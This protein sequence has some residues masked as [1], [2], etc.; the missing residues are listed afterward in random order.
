MLDNTKCLLTR[1]PPLLGANVVFTRRLSSVSVVVLKSTLVAD[2]FTA[3]AVTAHSYSWSLSAAEMQQKRT[4]WCRPFLNSSKPRWSGTWPT[5]ACWEVCG[6]KHKSVTSRPRRL[7]ANSARVCT[8]CGPV[9]GEIRYRKD[10]EGKR[11]ASAQLST[12]SSISSIPSLPCQQQCGPPESV[13]FSLQKARNTSSSCSVL[14]SAETGGTVGGGWRSEERRNYF[15]VILSWCY[16]KH[17]RVMKRY[18]V[19]V[20][21]CVERHKIHGGLQFEK[22]PFKGFKIWRLLIGVRL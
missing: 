15:W 13:A 3:F 20:C 6:G 22:E 17:F 1:L 9:W 5:A 7:Q 12:G 18:S 4:D 11:D 16:L 10:G 19:C 21:V 2:N 14:I 8:W